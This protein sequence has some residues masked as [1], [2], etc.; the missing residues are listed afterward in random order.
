[1]LTAY[2]LILCVFA[3]VFPLSQPILIQHPLTTGLDNEVVGGEEEGWVSSSDDELAVS[4]RL[5]ELQKEAQMK[6]THAPTP[7]ITAEEGVPMK[8]SSPKRILY[9]YPPCTVDS[10]S[11]G[12]NCCSVQAL[13]CSLEVDPKAILTSCEYVANTPVVCAGTDG[14][15]VA[16]HGAET[17]PN[18]CSQ[19]M[20]VETSTP[21]T[22]TSQS[23]KIHIVKETADVTRAPRRRGRDEKGKITTTNATFLFI[24]CMHFLCIPGSASSTKTRAMKLKLRTAVKVGVGEKDNTATPQQG[25]HKQ[26]KETETKRPRSRSRKEEKSTGERKRPHSEP[27]NKEKMTREPKRPHSVPRKDKKVTSES[28]RSRS[29]TKKDEK[30]SSEPKRPQSK[31]KDQKVSSEPKRPQSKSKKDRK[32]TD[33]QKKPRSKPR[34]DVNLTASRPRKADK[35]TGEPKRSRV[36]P[37]DV[38]LIIEPKRPRSKPTKDKKSTSEPKRPRKKKENEKGKTAQS[39]PG[40]VVIQRNSKSPQAQL[41]SPEGMYILYVHF[42]CQ[43]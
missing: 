41:G 38:K 28:K 4:M 13:R 33:V 24:L 11:E 36:R 6:Q 2:M 18:S 8:C 7:C 19:S 20:L 14:G 1:M 25:E 29:K 12:E 21:S 17:S 42:T 34:K 30:A 32:L 22:E 5:E 39:T 37:K 9:V 10:N 31:P 43:V 15:S 40:R 23:G 3:A 26:A 35:L 27:R 16:P